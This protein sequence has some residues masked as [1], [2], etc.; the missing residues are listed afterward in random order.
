M[1]N[2]P[3]K[4][5]LVAGG[6]GSGKSTLTTALGA[7]F[8]R[9][10]IM[11]LDDYQKPKAL[12]PKQADG[13]RNWE[14]PDVVDWTLLLRDLRD[15]LLGKTVEV[16]AW[17]SE[18]E[19]TSDARVSKHVAPGSII[20]LEGYLALWHPNVRALAEHSI[21][22]DVPSDL[23]HQR[24]LWTKSPEY[25]RDVLEP[26]HLQHIEPTRAF[27][28][29]VIDVGGK[30]PEAVLEEATARIIEICL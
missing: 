26:M 17:P 6:S 10:T 3:S 2:A 15:L 28:R 4:L 18:T 16:L 8:P 1:S 19:R 27:A 14:D 5:M 24:R 29:H 21:Y 7:R 12:V 13:R 22:L 20:V 11:H 9:W 23:R 25:I 30:S